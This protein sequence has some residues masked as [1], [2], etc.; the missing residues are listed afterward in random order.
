[1]IFKKKTVGSIKENPNLALNVI[2]SDFV[3]KSVGVHTVPFWVYV[4][5]IQNPCAICHPCIISQDE[6]S[7]RYLNPKKQLHCPHI[8]ATEMCVLKSKHW[9]IFVNCLK[10]PF[11]FWMNLLF[12]QVFLNTLDPGLL[13]SRMA[14]C[15]C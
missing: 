15:R 1:M 13:N 4:P 3:L 2:K 8:F 6:N 11:H 5:F 7:Y 9:F 14:Y 12:D 10:Y